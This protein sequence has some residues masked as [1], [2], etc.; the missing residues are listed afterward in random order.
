M[1]FTDDRVVSSVCEVFCGPPAGH[2]SSSSPK[3][4]DT[5]PAGGISPARRTGQVEDRVT[6]RGP[7]RHSGGVRL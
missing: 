4:G 6:G 2:L 3:P 5:D 7:K 1:P